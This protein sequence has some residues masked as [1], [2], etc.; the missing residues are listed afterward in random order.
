MSLIYD[1][2]VDI[3]LCHYTTPNEMPASHIHPQY[4]IY[5]CVDSVE[6]RMVINGTEFVYNHPCV[7]ISSPYTIHSMSV[8][9]PFDRYVIY[10]TNNIPETFSER[11]VCHE[12]CQAN[13]G[14][15]FN[16]TTD[17][18][19]GLKS[20]IDAAAPKTEEETE[21]MLA[22]FFKKLLA[23]CPIEEAM[24]FG[25]SSFYIQDVL[26]YIAESFKDSITA[27]DIA[28]KF[29]VSRSKLDRDFKHFTGGT[30]HNFMDNC[31]LNQSKS[32]LKTRYD[33]S[34]AEVAKQSGFINE[35]Y[36]FSYFKK[37][38]GKTPTEYR[39]LKANTN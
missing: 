12:L 31:R 24:K 17:Q 1:P 34:I 19:I 8:S 35:A 38:T 21:L 2:L 11:H 10:F 18:A 32:L 39:R 37:H 5:F 3:A 14:L 30:L 23:C 9:E 20:F 15:L 29:S 16:L 27:D 33:L 13:I 4:E 28:Y 26:Q 7:I 25:T 22:L 6:Q 36:F